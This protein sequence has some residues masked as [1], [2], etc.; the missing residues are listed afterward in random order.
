V[1]PSPPPPP[2]EL[3][4]NKTKLQKQQPKRKT[5]V[6][7]TTRN[8]P[9]DSI[10]KSKKY[11]GIGRNKLLAIIG[12]GPS[13]SEAPLEKLKGH[14]KIDVFSVNMPDSRVWP[15]AYWSFF[16]QSQLRRHAKLWQSYNGAIFNSTSIRE[17]RPGTILLKNFPGKGWSRDISKGI[18]IGR[19]S[20]YASMQIGMYMEYE[21]IYV[22][23]CDMNPDGLDGKLHFYGVNPDVEPKI[24]S[25]R[26]ERESDFYENAASILTEA[27]R[28]KFTFATEYNPWGFVKK[29][30]QTSHKTA[31][32]EMIQLA[33]TL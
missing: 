20:V 33:E 28:K 25:T 26:F 5:K 6:R 10:A 11:S 19:S 31:V 9:A 15:T 16:D 18:H 8:P 30:S 23:G 14:P 27:E 29:Y 4:V 12:N 2:A 24:R 21:Q 13:I 3:A 32:D 17:S 22:F 1:E 7:H